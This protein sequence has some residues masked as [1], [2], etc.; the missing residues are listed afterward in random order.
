[1]N[2]VL[3]VDDETEVLE[4]LSS[5]LMRRGYSVN[6]AP[7][8]EA[9]I[10]K[11]KTERFDVAL[12]DI[13]LPGMDGIM[14]LEQIKKI[15]AEMEVV[16]ITGHASVESVKLCMQKGA[17]DYIEKPLDT[18]R[19]AVVIEKALE[20]RQL[21]TTVALHEISKAIFSTIEMDEL[22][23]IIVDLAMKVLQA[24]DCSIMLFD[25]NNK[26]YIAFSHGLDEEIKKSTRL[27]IGE[28]IAGWVAE[29][30]QPIILINGLTNDPRFAGITGRENIKSAI[31]NPLLKNDKILGILAVSRKQI[32]ENFNKADLYKATVFASLVSLALDNANLY[33]NI[34]KL[35][36]EL[37]LVNKSLENKEKN[38]L[39]MV[40]QLRAAHE[41]LKA[42][43]YQLL[44]SAK[45]SALGRLVSD[46]AH[47]VN[48]PLMIIS[49]NAQL[50]LMEE[51]SSETVK[52]N[53]KVIFEES[54]HAKDILQRLLKFAR[55]S[56]DQVKDVDIN[57]SIE[58]V[59]ILLGHQFNLSNVQIIRSYADDLPH[60]SI[61]ECQMHEVFMN[62][63]NNARDAMP[64]GGVI[65]ITTGIEGD[66]LKID[67]CDTGCGMSEENMKKIFEPFFTT[68]E[69]GT[70]LGLSVSYGIVKVHNGELKLKSIPDKGTT[71]TIYLPLKRS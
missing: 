63:L 44:Q 18:N 23:K 65:T 5:N 34:Q 28:K 58:S 60:I 12:V 38:A 67:F 47:E 46:M 56:K 4:A 26:L 33:K 40:A 59:A 36:N 31:V 53:L 49:G 10:A 1:M 69:K 27:A 3:I 61:D 9:G 51:I 21:T 64:G 29:T 14:L 39:A 50:S 48:N 11:T 41:E 32:E 55:P 22:L 15:D 24:D 35:R 13:K 42:N 57:K 8:A 19:I 7:N 43:Q 37:I 30:K 2:R 6:T 25:E 71:A 45:L 70:G 17:Y 66:Y 62:L 20:K 52:N 54:Q 68:K 16:M